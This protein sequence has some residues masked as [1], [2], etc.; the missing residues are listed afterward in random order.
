MRFVLHISA[1]L[2]FSFSQKFSYFVLD[3]RW[4]PFFQAAAPGNEVNQRDIGLE[5]RLLGQYHRIDGEFLF[6]CKLSKRRL[7]YYEEL[8]GAFEKV[9]YFEWIKRELYLFFYQL[10][11]HVRYRAVL[12]PILLSPKDIFENFQTRTFRTIIFLL[13]DSYFLIVLFLCCYGRGGTNNVVKYNL[14]TEREEKQI[15]LP[16]SAR[17]TYYQW[18]GYTQ[19]DLAVDE[20][21]LWALWGY[22]GNSYRLRAQMID[23]YKGILTHGWHL[24][25]GTKE[26]LKLDAKC[27]AVL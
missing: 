24:S 17:K 13:T 23:A 5:T 26:L 27:H 6:N 18:S 21:G 22:S 8:A 7:D 20:Q 1:F 25:S 4:T 3:S 19:V 15:G 12:K 11:C 16:G 14:Q 2:P 9:K 10:A